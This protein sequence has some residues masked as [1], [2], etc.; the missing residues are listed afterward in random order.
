M[1]YVTHTL[2]WAFLA[3]SGTLL[4]QAP[5]RCDL[6]QIANGAFSKNPNIARSTLAVQGAQADWQI[7]RSVFDLNSFSDLSFRNSQNTLVGADPRTAF[8]EN[9]LLKANTLNFSAGVRRRLRTSQLV[10]AG[11]S[12]GFANNNFPFD[13]FSQP[14][15]AFIGNNAG[16]F[17]VSLSQPLLRGRGREI[18]TAQERAAVLYVETAKSN[19]EFANSLELAQIGVAYWNY[20]TAHKNL[21]IYRQNEARVRDILT[22]MKELVK[23]DKKPASDLI[24]ISAD[25][26]TQERL[27]IS[28][29][30]DLYSARIQLGRMIGL[31]KEESLSLAAP[32][33][34]FPTILASAYRTGLD[35]AD[36]IR[37][38][39][40]NR[41]DLRSVR[42]GQEALK[43]QYRL[44][45]NNLKPQLDLTGFL[46]HGSAAVGNGVGDMLSSFTNGP[47]RIL[48]TGARL[49]FTFPVNNNLARG[50]LMK[51]QVALSDQ[52]VVLSNIQRLIDLD[53]SN[54]L[55]FLDNSVANLQK[56]Q[57]V[58]K[59]NQDVFKDEQEKFQSGLTTI[60]S[61]I[62]F[63]ERLTSA[64]LGYIQAQ[65]QFALAIINLR[66][67][68]GTL[69]YPNQKGFT[70]DQK[71]FYTIPEINTK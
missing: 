42:Q 41:A 1:R 45:E 10:E 49:T 50:S 15:S 68:T 16:T 7:Q 33:N 65:R 25:L 28:A 29:E 37:L 70:V 59:Y 8:L 22:K 27:T 38:A 9:N 13:N 40:E 5:I 21:D 14:T 47:G 30:Q 11:V 3:S 6:L 48:T 4:G 35:K 32:E 57:E 69:L 12:Y 36:F 51:S 61:L 66:H 58:Y 67:N 31:D 23:G 44:A 18:A 60:L 46:S 17:N 39:K 19:N 63:Q 52:Q 26:V 62:L 54:D 55:N 53:I 20:Y 56:A 24:Q 71:S 43:M 64:Q 2:F 34:E